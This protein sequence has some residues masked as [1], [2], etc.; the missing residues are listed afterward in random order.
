MSSVER[1][2]W[3]AW[4]YTISITHGF[5]LEGGLTASLDE[6]F[7][8]EA[9]HQKA[10]VVTQNSSNDQLAEKHFLH[11]LQR[12]LPQHKTIVHITFRP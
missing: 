11:C 6:K 10:R 5:Y 12:I 9:E 2:V 7:R 3:T 8:S 1:D 4:K